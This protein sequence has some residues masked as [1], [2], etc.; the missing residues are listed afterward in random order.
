M[1]KADNVT[2]DYISD[3]D[4]FADAFNYLIYDGR[5]VVKPEGLSPVDTSSL[6]NVFG[7]IKKEKNSEFIQRYRDIIN[8]AII[9]ENDKATYVLLGIEAQTDIHYAMPVRNMIY[10]GLQYAKQVNHYRV[11]HKIR[12]HRSSAAE[13]LSGMHADDYLI[14]VITLVIYFGTEQWDGARR[15]SDMMYKT[16]DVI[17]KYVQDYEIVLIEPHSMNDNEFDKFSTDL[18]EVLKFI[19]Y[20]GNEK[21]MK[22]VLEQNSAYHN[23]Q[24]KAA[25]VLKEC[26]KLNVKIDSNQEVIDMCKA[27]DDHKKAGIREGLKEGIKEGVTEGT[28]QTK[29]KFAIKM[30]NTGNSIEEIADFF[31]ETEEQIKEWVLEPT[32]V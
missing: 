23:M 2:K 32:L 30:Y 31:E 5:A 17:M 19:K 1:G 4:V 13:F 7:D 10:D 27:W 29:K 8:K 15:L 20:A 6:L 18:G 21:F 3:I 9:Q 25:K 12:G 28:M 11:L 16:S 24:P 26:A 22:H 14:P